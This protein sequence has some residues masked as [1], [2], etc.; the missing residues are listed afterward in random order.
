MHIA[1]P[2]QKTSKQPFEKASRELEDWDQ[3]SSVQTY[4]ENL[5]PTVLNAYFSLGSFKMF[6]TQSTKVSESRSA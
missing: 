2:F 4:K 1:T 5:V 6:V 3:L